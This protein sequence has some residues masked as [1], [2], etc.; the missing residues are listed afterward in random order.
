MN[1]RHIAAVTAL[2]ALAL[3]GCG[4][5]IP[6]DSKPPHTP[7]KAAPEPVEETS[8]EPEYIALDTDSFLADTKTTATKCY[9]YGVGCNVTVKPE[10]TFTGGTDDIDPD[11][12]YEITYQITGDENGPIIET[13]Q[14]SNRTELTYNDSDLSTRSRSTKIRIEITDVTELGY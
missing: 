12:T 1:I 9:G 13:A 14:L 7:A 11:K 3:A 8:T 4:S 5:R 6:V 2:T 10:F